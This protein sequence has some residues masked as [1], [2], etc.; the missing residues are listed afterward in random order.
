MDFFCYIN[1][2]VYLSGYLSNPLG[3]MTFSN[4][5]VHLNWIIKDFP[6]AFVTFRSINNDTF[7]SRLIFPLNVMNVCNNFTQV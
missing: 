1:R 4:G 6:D 7:N 5:Q 2:E 3:N